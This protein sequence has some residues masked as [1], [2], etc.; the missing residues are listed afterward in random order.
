MDLYRIFKP[1]IYISRIFCLAPFAAVEV[2]GSTRYKFSTFWLLY[3]ISGV[4]VSFILQID[5]L[6]FHLSY[7]AASVVNV[8]SNVLLT[9][10]CVASIVSQV[11]CLC[12]GKNVIRILDRVSVLDK[13]HC[14]AQI[15]YCRLYKVFIILIICSIISLLVPNIL[16]YATLNTGSLYNFKVLYISTV[17]FICG[18]VLF[19]SD[20]QFFHFALLLKY[21][22][23]VLNYTIINF[24][25]PSFY[26]TRLNHTI[27][28]TS[29]DRDMSP[30]T[31]AFSSSITVLKSTLRKVYRHH[32]ALCDIC[33]SVNRT[34][35]VQILQSVMVTCIE[36]LFTAHFFSTEFTRPDLLKYYSS[37]KMVMMSSFIWVLV[38]SAKTVLQVV[39]CNRASREVSRLHS[40]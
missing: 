32:N 7:S 35:C 20:T 40:C 9:A 10:T 25:F 12:N 21:R 27:C 38:F 8:I 19:L 28:P 1:V 39:V 33:E 15:S 29:I 23:S 37:K 26:K 30:S 16:C 18:I 24:S 5:I 11:F 22:F 31:S 36:V 4:C 13:E 34:Y 17:V 3:S 2:A 6:W 14:G